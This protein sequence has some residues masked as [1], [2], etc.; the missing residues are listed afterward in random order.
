LPDYICN[1]S[2]FAC[3]E[4]NFAVNRFI[5]F[6]GL[7]C[8][9]ANGVVAVVENGSADS[10]PV[11][12]VYERDIDII[13]FWTVV[14]FPDC[15]SRLDVSDQIELLDAF[16]IPTIADRPAEVFHNLFE[17]LERLVVLK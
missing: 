11:A 15:D 1:G 7:I 9:D 10:T 4:A 17:H 6:V 8:D 16:S 5:V 14:C 13:C 2:G 12:S 3:P